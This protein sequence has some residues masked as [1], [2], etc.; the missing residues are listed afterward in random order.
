MTEREIYL[1]ALRCSA[2]DRPRILDELCRGRP[3]LRARIDRLVSA[4]ASLGD[5]LE[6][7]LTD[8]LER[9]GANT[10][11]TGTRIGAYHLIRLLGHGGMGDVYEAEQTSPFFRRVAVKLIKGSGLSADTLARFES[12]RQTLALMDHPHI[13]KMLDGGNHEGC[14]YFVM[15]LI[16]GIPI[17]DYCLSERLNLQ[18]RL[19]IF[20]EVCL[21]VQHAHQKGIIHR[22]LKP[23]NVLV[24]KVDGRAVP[25]IIDFGV[26]KITQSQ[27]WQS[28]FS[29]TAA[30]DH[31]S[32][33]TQ[34]LLVGTL[35]TMSPEQTRSDCSEVDTRSDIYSLGTLCY[36]LL[37]GVSPMHGVLEGKPSFEG[38]V[39]A[40]RHRVPLSP[41]R[42]IEKC[43]QTPSGQK[44]NSLVSPSQVRED[45]DWVVMKCLEKD[46]S[47]RYPS[48]ESLVRRGRFFD[49]D[50][51]AARPRPGAHIFA[52]SCNVIA[53]LWS[54]F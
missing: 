26:A 16:P 38:I 6:R 51:V 25:K 27:V 49:G 36:E 4:S 43:I 41:S 5:F 50:P 10:D 24:C 20:V 18:Q 2:E 19:G 31:A 47:L 12:E 32:T 1:Q 23:S 3:D 42:C 14:P 34:E 30:Q 33:V 29:N 45:L 35:E 40:I 11:R 46:P 15:E 21:A 9:G 8:G 28:Q 13:A 52:S 7:P 17:T 48:V 22:D 39:D 44:S 37:T 53:A 54:L